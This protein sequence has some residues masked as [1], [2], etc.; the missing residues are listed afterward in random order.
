MNK[1]EKQAKVSIVIVCM[2][3]LKNLLPCLE[4][5]KVHTKISHEVWVN[6]YMFTEENLAIVREKFPDARLIINNEIAG[7]AEN[8]NLVLRRVETE[9]VLI[10]NDDTLFKEPVL[11][12][13]VE[14]MEKTPEA[15]IMSPK[16]VNADGSLQSCGKNPVNWY[17]F[18]KE[19]T[20]GINNNFRKTIYTNGKGIFPSYNISGACFLIRTEFFKQHGFFDEYYFFC[21]EDIA[22]STNI[23]E[24]GG[25]CYVDSNITLYH[26]CGGTRKSA[27]KT[28]TLPAQ[29]IGCIH[30]H[31]RKS[32]ILRLFM[33]G[34]I[35]CTSSAKCFLNLMKG[36]K[37]EYKAQWHCM[38]AMLS[39]KSPKE[40]FTKYYLQLNKL[41]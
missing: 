10:L 26:L 23:N 9:Y 6:C 39:N 22:L 18:L 33:R 36:D 3:N 5:I 11:D 29:R 2:N 17:Y 32:L 19:D 21:P 28:A 7:F 24:L 12:E 34:W 40:L 16:L 4:S 8:N 14:S 41:K 37:I 35:L 25:K 20:F 15:S 30:F 1:I 31:G 27:V 38:Q 13:L